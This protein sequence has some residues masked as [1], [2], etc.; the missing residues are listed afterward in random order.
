M[1]LAPLPLLLSLF[2]AQT[3]FLS[4]GQQGQRHLLSFAHAS[5]SSD[6]PFTILNAAR[7]FDLT[8]NGIA[9]EKTGLLF[10]SQKETAAEFTL[11]IPSSLVPHL[12][13]L[14]AKE[15]RDRKSGKAAT[16]KPVKGK[17]VG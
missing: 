9:R 3:L 12:S 14:E 2:S 11:A 5:P 1:I 16:L 15:R 10:Q 7:H 17:I 13:Y 8:G 6:A 4:Q